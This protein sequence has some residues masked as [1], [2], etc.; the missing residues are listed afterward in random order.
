MTYVVS[1]WVFLLGTT[2]SRPRPTTWVGRCP[3]GVPIWSCI[4]YVSSYIPW[5]NVSLACLNFSFSY[6]YY[7]SENSLSLLFCRVSFEFQHNVCGRSIY[8]EGSIDAAFFLAKKVLACL[9]LLKF[10]ISNIILSLSFRK[11]LNL[12]I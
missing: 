7:M 12:H 2:N 5:W 3:W 6:F 4:P 11:K 9:K 1:L 10:W 8:A